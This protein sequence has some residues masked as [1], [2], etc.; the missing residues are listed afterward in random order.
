M[1][2]TEEKKKL[3]EERRWLKAMDDDDIPVVKNSESTQ[4]WETK[5]GRGFWG[6]NTTGYIYDKDNR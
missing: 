3:A 6:N 4:E 5:N 2:K 1:S